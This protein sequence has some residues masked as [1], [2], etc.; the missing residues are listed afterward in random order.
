MRQKKN[1][2]KKTQSQKHSN[3][4]RLREA[5]IPARKFHFDYEQK[6]KSGFREE[7]QRITEELQSEATKTVGLQRTQRAGE[8]AQADQVESEEKE[9]DRAQEKEPVQCGNEGRQSSRNAPR[10]RGQSG[11][12]RDTFEEIAQEIRI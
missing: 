10:E 11:L 4:K 12:S 3:Q 8:E 2:T 9:Q 6:P 1:V 7:T 5:R